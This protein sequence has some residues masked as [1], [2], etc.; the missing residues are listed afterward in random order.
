MRVRRRAHMKEDRQD[1]HFRDAGRVARTPGPVVGGASVLVVVG[2][3][4][5]HGDQPRADR[6][7]PGAQ[8]FS[9]VLVATFHVA[10]G[11]CAMRLLISTAV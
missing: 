4:Q 2:I 1:V 5:R 11:S 10:V 7:Q 6:A 9:T 8:L 3:K